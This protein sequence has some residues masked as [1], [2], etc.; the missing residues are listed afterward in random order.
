[1]GVTAA[2][3]LHE[4]DVFMRD[5][6]ATE[7][8]FSSIHQKID[9]KLAPADPERCGLN[10]TG[11]EVGKTRAGWHFHAL[12]RFVDVFNQRQLSLGTTIPVTNVVAHSRILPQKCFVT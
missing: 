4:E 12:G 9:E 6:D 10:K 3:T 1:M 5:L 8:Q 11:G 2:K 7:P